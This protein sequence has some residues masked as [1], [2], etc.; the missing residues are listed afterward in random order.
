MELYTNLNNKMGFTC[1]FPHSNIRL[2]QHHFFVPLFNIG[3]F[4]ENHLLISVW[5]YTWVF[6]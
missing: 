2:D 4:V 1:I 6:N 3:F 5:V